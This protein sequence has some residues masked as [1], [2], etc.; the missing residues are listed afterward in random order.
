M[1]TLYF[2]I[3]QIHLDRNEMP[4]E[5]IVIFNDIA[6]YITIKKIRDILDEFKNIKLRIELANDKSRLFLKLTDCFDLS[7]LQS[8]RN[9]II[10]KCEHKHTITAGVGG[11]IIADEQSITDSLNMINFIDKVKKNV[12]TGVKLIATTKEAVDKNKILIISK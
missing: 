2:N 12:K 7:L 1:N 9:S 3:A 6:I 8:N 5:P 11:M 4:H 10:C